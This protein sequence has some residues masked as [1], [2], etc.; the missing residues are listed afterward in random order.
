MEFSQIGNL[1]RNKNA[2]LMVQQCRRCWCNLFTDPTSRSSK[3][4]RSS[5]RGQLW[6]IR[7]FEKDPIF[8]VPFAQNRTQ[9]YCWAFLCKLWG[10][11]KEIMSSSGLLSIFPNPLLI[12]LGV[13]S[14]WPSPSPY[15]SPSEALAAIG[16]LFPLRC[17]SQTA[18]VLPRSPKNSLSTSLSLYPLTRVTSRWSCNAWASPSCLGVPSAPPRLRSIPKPDF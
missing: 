6:E 11:W 5:R 13:S 12:H 4:A 1:W 7:I 9:R 16:A 14:V 15:L 2:D 18:N 3:F 10:I 8:Y 17:H